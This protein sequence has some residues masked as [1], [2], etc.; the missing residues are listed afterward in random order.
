LAWVG[1]Q[2]VRWGLALQGHG[3]QPPRAAASGRVR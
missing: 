2:L 3:P 1:S